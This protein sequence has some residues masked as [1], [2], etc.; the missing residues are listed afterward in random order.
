M[1]ASAPP[2]AMTGHDFYFKRL[3]HDIDDCQVELGDAPMFLRMF[4]EEAT[5]QEL[6]DYVVAYYQLLNHLPRVIETVAGQQSGGATPA[7]SAQLTK[8]SQQCVDHEPLIAEALS[9]VDITV[10]QNQSNPLLDTLTTIATEAPLTF[11]CSLVLF[12]VPTLQ[13]NQVFVNACKTQELPTTFY[14]PLAEHSTWDSEAEAD[15]ITLNILNTFNE[16]TDEQQQDIMKG[17][18]Q[19][20]QGIYQQ[21]SA[22]ITT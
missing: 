20:L 11:Y 5:R 18:N 8:L 7:I 19:L 1:N 2:S 13:F 17:I 3:M 12:D 6:I 4:E 15:V 14:Q 22:L 16:I 21:E 10:D 9:A